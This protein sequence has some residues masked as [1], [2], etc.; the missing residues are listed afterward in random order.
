ME[1]NVTWTMFILTLIFITLNA[2][3]IVKTMILNCA[4][5]ETCNIDIIINVK[6]NILSCE[7]RLLN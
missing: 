6:F 7:N 1:M 2:F 4:N 5:L 3:N